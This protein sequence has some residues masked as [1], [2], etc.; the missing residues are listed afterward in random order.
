M[1]VSDKWM[2][3]QMQQMAASMA[4]PRPQASQNAK[5]AEK[6]ESFQDMM[7]K[8]KAGDTPKQE[9]TPAK[10]SEDAQVQ[11]PVQTQKTEKVPVT[12]NEDGGKTTELTAEQAAMVAAGYAQLFFKGDGSAM[13]VV[14]IDEE[15]NLVPPLAALGDNAHFYSGGE[16]ALL[17][18]DDW[19]M[20]P[21]PELVEALEQLFRKTG[22]PRSVDDILAQVEQ[23]LQDPQAQTK[24]EIKAPEAPEIPE[25]SEVGEPIER[26]VKLD[27]IDSAEVKDDRDDTN[28][29]LEAEVM[30]APLFRD[31]E[32]APVKV[33][34][35]FQLD[36]E[37][38]EMD[39]RLADTIR[40]AAQEGLQQIEIRLSPEKLGTLTIRLTQSA[41]GALQVVLHTAN[42]KAANLLNQHLDGLNQALQSYGQNQEVR[43][44]VQRNEDSQQAGQQQQQQTDPDGHG[45]HSHQQQERH[46]QENGHSGDFIQKLRLGLFG[47]EEN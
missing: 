30:A 47:P 12:K 24:V 5:P 36:T 40:V 41:D 29:G 39:A 18:G 20:E 45:Q 44:E 19:V 1:N 31:V 42:A 38:P 8:A 6:G 13:L 22:D 33:G 28:G 46:K 15:G 10:E 3:E 4:N 27:D 11:E 9:E 43:V 37:Q 25:A 7:D 35:N 16:D 21:T 17:A 32:A 26:P 2:L 14:A 23:K 34:E